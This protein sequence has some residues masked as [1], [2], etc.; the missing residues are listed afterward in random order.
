M[1]GSLEIKNVV[2]K[3]GGIV[4]TNDLSIH[5]PSGS[6]SAIIGPNGAGKTTLFN[7]I[8]GVVK[9]EEGSICLDGKELT[10]MSPTSIVRSGVGRAFQVAS[11]FPT[12]TVIETL[13]AC[14]AVHDGK[15]KRIIG[16]YPPLSMTQ[17][18]RALADLVGL[19]GIVDRVSDTLSH[20]DQKL[21]DIAIALANKPKV[22][23][24]DEPMAGMGHDERQSMV[25]CIQRLWK[26]EGTTLLF[27]EHDMDVVFGIA[28]NV[29]VMQLG[30]KIAEGTPAEV[31]SN[32]AVVKAYL[33]ENFQ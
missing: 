21:L 11:L 24:L 14:I 19:G 33:G 17:R 30:A 8:T 3:Y 16:N 15:L 20:G 27:V 28:Q 5:V 26:E 29:V 23:L 32:P 18:A 31:R 2:K 10:G 22:L 12:F 6:L 1:S 13:A 9:P 4:V 25:G 7:L